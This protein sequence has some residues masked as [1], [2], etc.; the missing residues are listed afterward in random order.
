MAKACAKNLILPIG[1]G[2]RIFNKLSWCAKVS[3]RCHIEGFQYAVQCHISIVGNISTS[4]CAAL[5]CNDD[6]TI[7][8][9]RTVNSSSCSITENID[10]FNII[11]SNHR[12]IHSWNTINNIVWLH[13]LALTERRRT[14]ESDTWRTIRVTCWRNH[15]TG[16]LTLQ[17]LCGVCIYTLIKVFCR[18]CCNWRSHIFTAHCTVAYDNDLVESL[19][20]SC[21]GDALSWSDVLCLITDVGHFQ[22]GI[23]LSCLESVA[24]VDIGNGTIRCTLFQYGHANQ[25]LAIGVL[26]DTRLLALCHSCCTT[27]QQRCWEGCLQHTCFR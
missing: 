17:H 10:R 5:C 26:D 2:S 1:I 13:S 12:N 19:V 25:R 11:G 15:Q 8:S 3:S 23:G 14:T 18:H 7:G 21:E 24:S 6:N 27:K 20:V 4:L 22:L 16:N 9:L